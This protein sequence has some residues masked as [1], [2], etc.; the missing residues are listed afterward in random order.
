[1]CLWNTNVPDNGR[2]QIWL[3]SQGQIPW[4]QY[5]DLVTRN[6]HVQYESSNNIIILLGIMFIF[7]NYF[8]GKGQK[9]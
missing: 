8:K 2:F 7:F 3:K 1:M 9:P 6:A 5:K 4:Y